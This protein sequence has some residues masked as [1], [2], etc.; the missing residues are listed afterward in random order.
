[1]T[2]PKLDDLDAV[3]QI[4]EA[5]KDFRPEEQQRIFRWASEKLNLPLGVSGPI[6]T[7]PGLSAAQASSPSPAAAL[8]ATTSVPDIKTFMSLKKPKSDVQFAA[9]TAYYHRF[10]AAPAERKD[11]ITKDDLQ[12][13]ARKA[14]RER[15][16][17]PR[18][19]LNNAHRLGLLDK[20]SEKATFVINSV[21][22]N[23]RMSRP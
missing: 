14:S 7:S 12:E 10:E 9:A 23:L 22:E 15:F 11:A 1:M 4:V 18:N 3:R 17:D 20:G 19:T 16:A 8:N 5:V 6:G 13:A 2:T 21:G